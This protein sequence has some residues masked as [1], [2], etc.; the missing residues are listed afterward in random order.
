[1]CLLGTFVQELAQTHPQI[2]NVCAACFDEQADFLKQDIEEA[3]VKYAPPWPRCWH[4]GPRQSG[5]RPGFG[6]S[7][8]KPTG[9]SLSP[10]AIE[11]L[12]EADNCQ[13]RVIRS[14][15]SGGLTIQAGNWKKTVGHEDG[16]FRQNTSTA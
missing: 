2:R 3:K 10:E 8:T 5:A 9:N 16:A 6:R 14:L 13:S 12:L 1:G 15:H 7:S 4:P 11:I